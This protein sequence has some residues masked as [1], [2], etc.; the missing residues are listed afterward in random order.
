M[1]KKHQKRGKE[2]YVRSPIFMISYKEVNG[3]EIIRETD[4]ERKIRSMK[5]GGA[6]EVI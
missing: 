2:E 5:I 3:R 1:E 4:H 6:H